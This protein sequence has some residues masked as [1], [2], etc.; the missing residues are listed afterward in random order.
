MVVLSWAGLVA[1]DPVAPAAQ[2]GRADT[3]ARTESYGGWIVA[4]D[5][6]SLLLVVGG[7]IA[8]SPALVTAGVGSYFLASPIT[9]AVHENFGM[10]VL[11]LTARVAIPFVSAIVVAGIAGGPCT[12]RE[13]RDQAECDRVLMAGLIGAGLGIVTAMTLD[14]TLMARR[15]VPERKAFMIS[16]TAG[17]SKTS[18]WTI[19]A[20]GLF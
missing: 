6:A 4:G 16:P 1:A 17:W 19:G 7:A 13:E 14:A 10:G 9:H 3:P 11:S 8:D 12:L 15:R 18:G 2:R 20:Q 5:G